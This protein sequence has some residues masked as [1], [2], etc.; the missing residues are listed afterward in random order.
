MPEK[1]QMVKV[2]PKCGSIAV[3][4]GK[5]KN[6]M[7]CKECSYSDIFPE[8]SLAD[9]QAFREQLANFPHGKKSGKKNKRAIKIVLLII[10]IWLALMFLGPLLFQLF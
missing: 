8:L 4:I 10:V 9:V 1:F 6:T 5:K 2:C 3:L 7:Q